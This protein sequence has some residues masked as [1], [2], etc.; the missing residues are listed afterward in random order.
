MYAGF[1]IYS[2]T[3]SSHTRGA[4]KGRYIV[5]LDYNCLVLAIDN[6]R[7]CFFRPMHTYYVWKLETGRH[8]A[9]VRTYGKGAER[10]MRRRLCTRCWFAY[11]PEFVVRRHLQTCRHTFVNWAKWLPDRWPMRTRS[12]PGRAGGEA[13]PR[14]GRRRGER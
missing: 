1:V 12:R 2:S 10:P 8:M 7:Q 9:Y 4:T 6:Y 14:L 13:A 11:G 3:S 5:F